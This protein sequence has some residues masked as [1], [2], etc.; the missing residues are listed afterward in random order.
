MGVL[1]TLYCLHRLPK[2]TRRQKKEVASRRK[3]EKIIY[4]RFVCGEFFN[5]SRHVSR[6]IGTEELKEIIFFCLY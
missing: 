6:N 5:I 4:I 2:L 3:A 1:A